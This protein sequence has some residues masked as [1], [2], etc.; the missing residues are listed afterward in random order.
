[1]SD[2]HHIWTRVPYL[3][4][5]VFEL[6]YIKKGVRVKVLRYLLHEVFEL[7]EDQDPLPLGDRFDLFDNPRE[8]GSVLAW[9]GGGLLIRDLGYFNTWHVG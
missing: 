4:H 3:L 1:M 6:E 9:W 8:L 7:D 5:E 2:Y